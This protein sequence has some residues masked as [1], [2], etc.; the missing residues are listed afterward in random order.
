MKAS[1]T[2]TTKVRIGVTMGGP[3]AYETYVVIQNPGGLYTAAK[4]EVTN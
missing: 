2:G 4:F 1:L 3:G